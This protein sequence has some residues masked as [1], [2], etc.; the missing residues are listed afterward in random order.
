LG[1]G[2]IDCAANGAHSLVEVNDFG[3]RAWRDLL[4]LG[5]EGLYDGVAAIDRF[6]KPALDAGTGVT[7][8]PREEEG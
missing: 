7:G 1:R 8:T 5:P 2:D 6:S 3:L 4:E